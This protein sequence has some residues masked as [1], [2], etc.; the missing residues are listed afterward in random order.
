MARKLEILILP[1]LRRNINFFYA[2]GDLKGK[3][4]AYKEELKQTELEKMINEKSNNTIPTVCKPFCEMVAKI[5]NENGINAQTVS[6]DTDMFRHTDVLLT[7][8]TGKQIIINYLEDIENIQAGMK[9][10][11]FASHSYYERRYKK[12]EGGLTTDGKDI[13][14]IT[15]LSENQM[16]KID[17]NLGY[18]KNNMYMDSVIEQIKTEFLNFKEIMAENEWLTKELEMEKLGEISAN[19]KLNEKNKVYEKYRNLPKDK[20]LEL[21]LDWLLNYFN[22]RM[23]IKGHT[24]FVMY[25]SRALLKKVLTP[26]EYAQITR[27]ECFAYKDKLPQNTILKEILDTNNSEEIK[28]SRFCMIKA[29]NNLYAFSTKPNKYIKLREQDLNEIQKY[30]HISK[31]EKPSDLLLNLCDRGNALPLVFNPLG[32]KILNERADL[33]DKK[34]S[35]EERKKAIRCAG[36]FNKNY[37]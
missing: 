16:N 31:T 29:G 5:L 23:N 19:E 30:T 21:K 26:E 37:R 18:K 7:T 11:D 4:K 33:I 17:T 22:D 36:K 20:E 12:F 15:F 8:K 9:T 6:C 25:H 13:S 28:K 3:A 35:P 1:Y 2:G 24:D 32:T 34:L 10:P 14:N 27:Y